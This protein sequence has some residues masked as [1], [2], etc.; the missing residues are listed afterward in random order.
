MTKEELN[1]KL[2]AVLKK[3]MIGAQMQREKI[4]YSEKDGFPHMLIFL[5]PNFEMKYAPV[6]WDSDRR[7]KL[8]MRAVSELAKQ[9]FCTAVIL[10]SDAR[11]A[12]SRKI[13]PV[14]GLPTVEEVGLN[15]YTRRYVDALDQRFGGYM[16]N[17]PPEY[18]SE[19][20]VVVA[21]GP[22][23]GV[24]MEW[25]QYERGENDGIKWIT[26]D[27]EMGLQSFNLLPDW[28]V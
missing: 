17:M 22:R 28:W 23:F 1:A 10:I 20:V 5:G 18:F 13:G 12:D 16:G 2:D 24:K 9:M 25:A 11:W 15:E 3:A 27:Y 19:A 4:P 8:V 14:L 6:G 26:N 7:K 21:K